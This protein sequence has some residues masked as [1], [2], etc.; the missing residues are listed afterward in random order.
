MARNT[1]QEV[2]VKEINLE[3]EKIIVHLLKGLV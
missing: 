3:Q 2:N 1:T